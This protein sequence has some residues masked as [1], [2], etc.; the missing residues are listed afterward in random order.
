MPRTKSAPAATPKTTKPSEMTEDQKKA[1]ALAAEA[2]KAQ[3][4]ADKAAA[5]QKKAD[6]AAKLKA[7]KEAAKAT[8]A[9]EKEKAV[10][11]AT[12]TADKEVKAIRVQLEKAVTLD[13]KGDDHR[14]SAAVRLAAVK[15]TLEEAGASFKAWYDKN[16]ADVG[17]KFE[18]VRKLVWVGSQEDPPKALADMRAG[19]AEQMK[20]ARAK[21]KAEKEAEKAKGKTPAADPKPKNLD[22]KGA[23]L[24]AVETLHA[25][26]DS[27]QVDVVKDIAKKNGLAVV[28]Q[29]VAAA[30]AASNGGDPVE[31]IKEL[32]SKLDAKGKGAV[33][34]ALA[35]A[36]GMAF[37]NKLSYDEYLKSRQG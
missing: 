23:F 26:P 15:K 20:E 33:L 34:D 2:A 27:A 14:L 6:D 7:E 17:Y 12:E 37:V 29:S 5:K 4:E 3:K 13:K 19:N 22:P 1:A 8:A 11:A 18:S 10:A 32:F 30:A 24:S 35:Q 9:A 25:A 16:I 31:T 36:T 21:A 28:S